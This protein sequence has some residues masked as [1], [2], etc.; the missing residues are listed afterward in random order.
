MDNDENIKSLE[1]KAI[2]LS[3]ELLSS[4]FNINDEISKIKKEYYK[5]IIT[6]LNIIKKQKE[7]LI[8]LKLLL[9]EKE[10]EIL[11][12]DIMRFCL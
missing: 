8:D 3:N 5:S 10:D 7:E 11:K 1:I 12:K 2:I 6:S 4:S 9:L